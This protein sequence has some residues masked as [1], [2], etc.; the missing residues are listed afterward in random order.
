MTLSRL[1]DYWALEDPDTS[2]RGVEVDMRDRT[3]RQEVMPDNVAVPPGSR[4][5]KLL[6]FSANFVRQGEAKLTIPL[7]APNGDLLEELDFTFTF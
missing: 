3:L 6:V 4:L 5:S 1:K 7:F 2:I